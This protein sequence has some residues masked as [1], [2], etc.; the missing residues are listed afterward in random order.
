MRLRQLCAQFVAS[1][2]PETF[3]FL[4]ELF[5]GALLEAATT[6]EALL[7]KELRDLAARDVPRF[8]RLNRRLQGAPA[9]AGAQ[10]GRAHV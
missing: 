8:A 2:F 6:G 4:A 5:L 1:L 3:P 7:D 10:I 9:A